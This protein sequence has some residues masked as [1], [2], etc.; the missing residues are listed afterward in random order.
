MDKI[1][2]KQVEEFRL[3]SKGNKTK[4]T[5]AEQSKAS[6]MQLEAH[7]IRS[8]EAVRDL[9]ENKLTR[10]KNIGYV[11]ATPDGNY[12]WRILQKAREDCNMLWSDN[13][14]GISSS[15]PLIFEMNRLQKERAT[16]L[17]KALDCLTKGDGV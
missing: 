11:D 8:M 2:K 3:I 6:I 10:Y 1:I 9:Y 7:L 17:D 12:A 5:L 15:N 16:E 13:T 4:P 14:A